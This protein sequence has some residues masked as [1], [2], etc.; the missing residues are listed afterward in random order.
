MIALLGKNTHIWWASPP[1]PQPIL[2]SKH[3][4]NNS[5]MF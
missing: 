5:F 3:H 1:R 4:G 2:P